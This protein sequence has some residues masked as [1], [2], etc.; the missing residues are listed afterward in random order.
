MLM[1]LC[2]GERKNFGSGLLTLDTMGVY[3][4]YDSVETINSI[5]VS[6]HTHILST[7]LVKHL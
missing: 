5:N 6:K 1:P 3:Y 2:F 4:V 7:S